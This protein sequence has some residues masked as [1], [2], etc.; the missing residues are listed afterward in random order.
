VFNLKSTQISKGLERE[1]EFEN[2][3]LNLFFTEVSEER[4]FFRILG[5]EISRMS[6]IIERTITSSKRV[7]PFF[8]IS[9][10]GVPSLSF[11]LHFL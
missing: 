9:P 4:L 6:E 1:K 7:N 3:D 5:K 10:A 11:Y 8:T 2:S